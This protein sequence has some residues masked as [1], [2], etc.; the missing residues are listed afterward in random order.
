MLA[1]RPFHLTPQAGRGIET[2]TS[3]HAPDRQCILF[4]VA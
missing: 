2:V 3:F 4:I 1:E